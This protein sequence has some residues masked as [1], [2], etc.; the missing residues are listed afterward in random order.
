MEEPLGGMCGVELNV[1]KAGMHG[2]DKE[3]VDRVIYEM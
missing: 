2:V 1:G 3:K